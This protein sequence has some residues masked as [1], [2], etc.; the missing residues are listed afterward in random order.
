MSLGTAEYAAS[1]HPAVSFR[2]RL[3]WP[4]VA[5][6]G[7]ILFPAF[8]APVMLRD[9][10]RYSDCWVNVFLPAARA[11]RAGEPVPENY[12]YPP[13]MALMAVPMTHAPLPVSRLA[14]YV[15][16]VAATFA[17]LRAAWLLSGGR[18][19]WR[20]S[21]QDA[22]VFLLAMLLVGHF[23]IAPMQNR[24]FDMVIA[25]LVVLGGLQFARGANLGAAC[26]WG[27]AAAMKCTPLLL[28][29]YLALCRRWSLALIVVSVAVGWNGAA[30]ILCPKSTGT[31]TGDWFA[32][33]VIQVSA[34]EIG[35]WKSDIALNQSLSGL[36]RRWAR[37]LNESDPTPML[38]TH[39][40]S[41]LILPA[42]WPLAASLERPAKGEGAENDSREQAPKPLNPMA[43]AL[44][45]GGVCLSALALVLG[46]IWF[47][48]GAKPRLNGSIDPGRFTLEFANVC[49][50]MLL[51]S[52]MTSKAHYAVLALPA[53]LVGREFIHRP[54]RW[55][56]CLIIALLVMGPCAAKAIAGKAWGDRLL[57]LG[58]PTLFA[59]AMLFGLWHLATIKRSNGDPIWSKTSRQAL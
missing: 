14:W 53:L 35:D 55:L 41:P 27:S 12:A 22:A 34:G 31:Y 17:M 18:P 49:V 57:T 21:H 56:W 42:D 2:A 30:E 36:G 38:T 33:H 28:V 4:L 32:R 26:L 45:R 11:L 48:R 15:V 51:L 1:S 13:A 9:G 8:L 20:L 47:H 5:S 6:A 3:V 16:N 39:S 23:V 24:Q 52:P 44:L 58:F 29:P 37:M 40:R 10:D 7:A 59:V 46:S 54:S 50:L 25:A 43:A 19:D